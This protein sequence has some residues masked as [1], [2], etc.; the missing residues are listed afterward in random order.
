M[1]RVLFLDMNSFFASVEQELQPE[2]RGRPVAVAAVNVPTGCCI[3]SSYEAKAFGVKTG[4]SVA[5]ARM[6]CRGIRIVEARPIEYVRCHHAIVDAVQSCLPI[7][8]V[9]SIDEMSC[10]LMDN[11]RDRIPDLARRLKQAIRDQAGSSLR[12]SIGVAPNRLLA[13]IAGDMQK[14][15]GLTVWNEEHLPH[16]L[17]PLELTDLPGIASRMQVRL[18]ATGIKTVEQLC[19]APEK[20]LETAWG[21]VVGRWWYRW[22]RGEDW[23]EPPTRRRTVGHSHVL[24]PAL[25]T[26]EATYA[27]IVKL[28]AK[29]A[30]RMRRIGYSADRLT[31][32][33][34]YLGGGGWSHE[35]R[36][37]GCQDTL[38]M[39][40][41][42][43]ASWPSRLVGLP[44]RVSATLHKL[45][46]AAS[47]PGPLFP[48]EA[49]RVKLSMALDRIN[50]RWGKDVVHVGVT[51]DVMAAAPTRI[52]FT[53]IPDLA[54][55]F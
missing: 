53:Q 7:S 8:A 5:E 31:V 14:P 40:S 46:S 26:H 54:R 52:S 42:F 43:T 47:M 44:L 17:Y 11:E 22:L 23:R 41:A 38:T 1:L 13:K 4:V 9:H 51:H 49:N 21:G 32:G 19:T 20:M 18:N 33:V 45:S 36:F 48:G 12:C 2:L 3:A 16:S 34:D 6:L 35:C 27:V 37:L 28:I 29:A 15:D 55:D 10:R 30:T 50:E 24:P 39:V 25:R